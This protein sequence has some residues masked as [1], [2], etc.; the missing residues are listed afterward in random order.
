MKSH[1]TQRSKGEILSGREIHLKKK[2]KLPRTQPIPQQDV[3]WKRQADP[4]G[5]GRN[6]DPALALLRT[7]ARTQQA[8]FPRQTPSD[9]HDAQ[10]LS[11]FTLL[12]NLEVNDL[13]LGPFSRC[14]N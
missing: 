12:D 4:T 5:Q 10:H 14:G 11:G 7:E 3:L 6:P 2:K 9:R 1:F 13:L 8:T